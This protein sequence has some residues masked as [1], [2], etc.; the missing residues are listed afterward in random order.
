MSGGRR[1]SW[2]SIGALMLATILVAG[3]SGVLVH[4]GC[5]HMPPPLALNS[6]P[7]PGT[8]RA[9][10]CDAIDVHPP[11]PAL[12]L[13]SLLSGAVL[14]VARRLSAVWSAAIALL[15]CGDTAFHASDLSSLAS[16]SR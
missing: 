11:W 6:A 2:T 14:A 4:H 16:G 10:Y 9:G 5:T 8:P 15:L 12:A 7:E 1:T 3:L 13:G